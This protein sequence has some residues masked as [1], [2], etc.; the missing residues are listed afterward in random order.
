MKK[1][2][3]SNGDIAEGVVLVDRVTGNPNQPISTLTYTLLT[4]ETSHSFTTENM[5]VPLTIS[6]T[7]SDITRKIE[8]SMNN[9]IIYHQ[10]DY[11]ATTNS[12]EQILTISSKFTNG[13][14]TGVAGNILTVSY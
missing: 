14:V 11:D 1:I 13:K 4:G 5:S 10:V 8:I 2:I 12:S 7:S 9:G 3:L 6:W